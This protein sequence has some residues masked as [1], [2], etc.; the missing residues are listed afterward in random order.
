MTQA[1]YIY[2]LLS[3]I[4]FSVLLASCEKDET[5]FEQENQPATV[6][7]NIQQQSDPNTKANNAMGPEKENLIYDIW[8]LQYNAYGELTSASGIDSRQHLR[9]G[10]AGV[11]EV[12]DLEVTLR[13]LDD[14]TICLVANLGDTPLDN[15][16]IWPDNLD[17]FKRLSI[18]IDFLEVGSNDSRYGHV[19][20]IALFGYYKGAVTDRM[21][22]NVSLGRLITRVRLNIKP[23]YQMSGPVELKLEN[24]RSRINIFPTDTPYQPSGSTD[25]ERAADRAANYTSFTKTV[26]NLGTGGIIQYFYMGENINPS[27]E[28][29]TKLI[30]SNAGKTYTI[31]LGTESPETGDPSSRNLSL[32]RNSGYNFG[33]N[34]RVR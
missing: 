2:K 32:D 28:D 16:A 12:L 33:I 7:L 23:N 10:Q 29:A 9:V 3:I 13:A 1:K 25:E 4:A 19:N 6:K 26:N 31:Y 30:V 21:T 17:A 14:C 8:L 11:M 20:N 15:N 27:T 18:P 22:M 24:V 34:L 5:L